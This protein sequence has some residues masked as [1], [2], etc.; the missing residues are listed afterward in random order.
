MGKEDLDQ[1][2]AIDREAFPSQWPP[3][4]YRQEL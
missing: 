2:N 3:A 1:I 4:N